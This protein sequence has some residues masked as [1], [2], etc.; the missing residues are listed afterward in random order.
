MLL[1]E[2]ANFKK[3]KEQVVLRKVEKKEPAVSEVAL[4]LRPLHRRKRRSR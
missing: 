3:L 1:E 2:V 4:L